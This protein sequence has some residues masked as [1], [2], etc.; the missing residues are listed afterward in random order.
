MARTRLAARL[1]LECG[2]FSPRRSQ[3]RLHNSFSRSTAAKKTSSRRNRWT[4]RRSPHRGWFLRRCI[5][6]QR[7][8]RGHRERE[9]LCACAVRA[10]MSSPSPRFARRSSLADSEREPKIVLGSSSKWRKQIL[11]DMGY[12][13]VTMNPDI[14]ERAFRRVFST[15]SGH[16]A[17]ALSATPTPRCSRFVL[18][19]QSPTR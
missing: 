5:I 1:E 15:F 10:A 14:D 18:P 13:F 4:I 2:S 11:A 17:D 12:S 9:R 7:D 16:L 8:A 3:R 6:R 19:A